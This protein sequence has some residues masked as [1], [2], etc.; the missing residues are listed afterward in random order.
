MPDCCPTAAVPCLACEWCDSPT[1]FI[2]CLAGE[3][4]WHE[5]VVCGLVF[6]TIADETELDQEDEQ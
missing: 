4:D 6:S 5:C 3:M 2:G 1:F